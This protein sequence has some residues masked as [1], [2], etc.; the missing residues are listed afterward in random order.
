M[1][2]LFSAI[3]AIVIFSL[4]TGCRQQPETAESASTESAAPAS[5]APAKSVFPPSGTMKGD[6]IFITGKYVLFFGTAKE[7]PDAAE[8]ARVTAFKNSASLVI[9]SLKSAKGPE[10]SYTLAEHIVIYKND[11]TSMVVSRTNFK[12]KTGMLLMDGG[13]PPLIRKGILD[14]KEYHDVIATYFMT[15][16][17]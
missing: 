15:Q 6:T 9:D 5:S 1:T 8:Q 13:Q 4:I 3:A 2:R 10:A 14:L 17:P 11:G 16:L 12:E 7:I